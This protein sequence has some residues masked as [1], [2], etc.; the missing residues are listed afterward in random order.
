[1]STRVDLHVDSQF[2]SAH[3]TA[4]RMYEVDVA[5]ITLGIERPLNDERTFVVAFHQPRATGRCGPGGS[6][7]VESET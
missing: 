2:V 1:V 3:D 4:R 7:A 5:R 6:V